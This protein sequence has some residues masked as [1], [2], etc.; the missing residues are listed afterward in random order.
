[1]LFTQFGNGNHS[2]TS[3]LI[4]FSAQS[5]RLRL[6]GFAR[7]TFNVG[8]EVYVPLSG[9]ARYLS[10]L[11]TKARG[12][13]RILPHVRLLWLPFKELV[14]VFF[15]ECLI[16]MDVEPMPFIICFDKWPDLHITFSI[17]SRRRI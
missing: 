1:M 16:F 17:T 8:L 7:S 3:R 13:R 11:T 14:T 2:S 4:V 9:L 12:T 15:P 6:G 10:K 5:E